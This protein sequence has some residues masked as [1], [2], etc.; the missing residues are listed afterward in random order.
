LLNKLPAINKLTKP[1][2]RLLLNAL[3]GLLLN[4]YD[5]AGN[6]FKPKNLKLTE[7]KT[8]NPLSKSVNGALTKG[9]ISREEYKD[10]LTTNNTNLR[11]L[12]PVTLNS[13]LDSGD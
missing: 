1:S 3:F 5:V 6:Y 11:D 2:E 13:S 12:S 9:T 10:N 8:V 4:H 7:R